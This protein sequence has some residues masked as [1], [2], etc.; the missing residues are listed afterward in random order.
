M[1][2][3]DNMGG[4][5]S[6]EFTLHKG[7]E[8]FVSLGG[9]CNITFH[10]NHRWHELPIKQEGI[11]LNIDPKRTDAGL[12][13]NIKGSITC[14]H[15]ES[16]DILK[17]TEFILLRYQTPD[18]IWRVAGTKDFPLSITVNPLTPSKPSGFYGYEI[19]FEG[20]QLIEPPVHIQ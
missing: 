4:F 1:S 11:S 5:I 3:F 19:N 2:I 6:A 17:L 7:V 9:K 10:P 8:S 12:T 14:K 18:N 15:S 13:Y 20:N 16:Y